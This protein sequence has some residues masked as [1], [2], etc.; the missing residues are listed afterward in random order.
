M[1]PPRP[2][3]NNWPRYSLPPPFPP[4]IASTNS[5][6]C[7]LPWHRRMV[8]RRPQMTRCQLSAQLQL[9]P[10]NV[11]VGWPWHTPPSALHGWQQQTVFAAGS[12][13]IIEIIA[14]TGGRSRAR[15]SRDSGPKCN[16]TFSINKHLRQLVGQGRQS[17]WQQR[18]ACCGYIIW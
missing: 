8:M 18:F 6:A 17:V 9:Q 11:I 16:F 7:F 13:R 5:F 2:L 14:P 10:G 12:N 4:L 3:T 15:P 1:P